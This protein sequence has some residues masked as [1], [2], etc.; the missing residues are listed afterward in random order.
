M[1]SDG[2]TNSGLVTLLHLVCHHPFSIDPADD[3]RVVEYAQRLRH[4]RRDLRADARVMPPAFDAEPG[5]A[6]VIDDFTDIALF[7]SSSLYLQER[8]RLRATEG[9]YVVTTTA[10]D[11]AFDHY[12]A[13]ELGLGAVTWL[14][15]ELPEHSIRIAQ[16]CWR[17]R[18]IRNKLVRAMRQEGL[19]YLH[20]HMANRDVWQ[21]AHL[22][23]HTA[24]LPM[25]VIAPPAGIARWAND[26]TEFARVVTDILGPSYMPRTERAFNFALLSQRVRELAQRGSRLALKL[27]DACGGAGNLCFEAAPLR[28]MTLKQIDALIRQRV[29]ELAWPRNGPLLI[30]VWES[31]V[32]ESASIQTWIPADG[33]GHPILE[34]I[35]SQL[36]DNGQGKFVGCQPLTLPPHLERVV[37]RATSLLTRLFQVLHYYGRCSF[38]FLL[39]G[40]SLEDSQVEF[41]ECNARWGGTSVPMTLVNRLFGDWARQPFAAVESKLPQDI[42]LSRL[43]QE[44][45]PEIYTIHHP[46]GWLIPYNPSRITALGG[47]N[48]V[49]LGDSAEQL[50][51]RIRTEL[52]ALLK[53]RL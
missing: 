7:D 12:V 19:K 6:L 17:N 10:P 30:N 27:P 36:I 39:V 44:L 25:T 9:D 48:W 46:T 43:L 32:L 52:P 50:Q 8:A 33:A 11:A 28:S 51:H 34:G 15:V 2:R 20:P 37:L 16:T 3:E 23:S 29:T 38:D 22:L 26:K 53:S 49:V 47:L 24:H 40:N 5:Q 4:T 21:L 13:C 18:E 14:D 45:R 42:T 31:N 41:L 35:F 1:A